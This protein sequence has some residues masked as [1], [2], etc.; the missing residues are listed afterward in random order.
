MHDLLY[1]VFTLI[2][3]IIVKAGKRRFPIAASSVKLL[4]TG[5]VLNIY[6]LKAHKNI[7]SK[8][9]KTMPLIIC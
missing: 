6:T 2:N 8:K 1:A 5:I 9:A 4:F 7:M 3:S